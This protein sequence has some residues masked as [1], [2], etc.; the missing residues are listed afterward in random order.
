MPHFQPDGYPTICPYLIVGDGAAA[1]AF[2]TKVLGARERM[3]LAAPGGRIGHAELTVGDAVIMLAD[4]APSMGAIAPPAEGT[5]H[6]T[7][8]MYV[9][10]ADKTIKAAEEAG[11]R[12]LH[13][14]ETKFYGDR[15]G[16]FLDP[17]GHVWHVSTHVE[18]VPPDELE[19]RA[20]ALMSG[21]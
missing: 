15:G 1:V 18:D 17:F 6:V 4:E 16:T 19:R 14:V 2:Y 21:T 11:A 12:I 7:L 20:S 3:R 8:H 5:R 13:P 10:D 9:S